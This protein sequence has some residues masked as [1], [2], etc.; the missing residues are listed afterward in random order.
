[1][2]GQL[3]LLRH[4]DAEPHDARPDPQRRLTQRGERQARVAGRAIVRL[5][6]RFDAVLTSPKVRARDTARLA[7]QAWGAE[8]ELYKP[9]ASGF[10]GAAALEALSRAGGNG[11]LLL[12]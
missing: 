7:A 3:W 10:D 11:R 4:G 1:M 12:V 5:R 2:A 6:G 8:P 9:L